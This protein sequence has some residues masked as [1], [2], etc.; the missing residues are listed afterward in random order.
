M[1]RVALVGVSNDG[2][3]ENIAFGDL[4]EAAPDA[5]MGRRRA[6]RDPLREPPGHP[7]LQQGESGFAVEQYGR[8]DVHGAT[9]TLAPADVNALVR[10]VESIE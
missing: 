6:R 9:S 4:V 5:I 1:P 7:A 2:R 3:R 8:I 10:Y